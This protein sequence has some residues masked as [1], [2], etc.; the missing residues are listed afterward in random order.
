MSDMNEVRKYSGFSKEV[1]G[2][3]WVEATFYTP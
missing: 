3:R 2:A 1:R